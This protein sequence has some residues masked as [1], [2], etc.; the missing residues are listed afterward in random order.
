MN[1]RPFPI[2][3][4]SLSI[5]RMLQ[6]GL[7]SGQLTIVYG[8]P[9]TGKTSLAL[10]CASECA[11]D[12]RKVLYIDSDYSFHPNRLAQMTSEQFE[13]ISKQIIII[14]PQTFQDQSLLIEKLDQYAN[15]NFGLVVIDTVTTLYL[16]ELSMLGEAFSLNR[17]LNRQLAYLIHWA[18]TL[19]LSILA[20]SQVR[21]S[22]EDE[23]NNAV[24]PVATRVV[25]YWATNILR[26]EVL[27]KDM[28]RA[29]L[30][31]YSDDHLSGLFVSYKISEKGI[32]DVDDG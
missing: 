20:T 13:N 30:E 7:Y 1:R 14:R 25:Q 21:S 26:L 18:K 3:T 24:L 23:V 15:D 2:S 22:V 19:D 16:V 12:E 11:N 31:K 10:R 6:G 27:R 5:D 32:I 28:F 29:V 17:E 8:K 4:G 9:R